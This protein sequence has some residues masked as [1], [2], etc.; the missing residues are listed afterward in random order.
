MRYEE[1]EDPMLIYNDF[2]NDK[3]L[4]KGV[5]ATEIEQV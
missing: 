3:I 2:D 5:E 1:L 4:F